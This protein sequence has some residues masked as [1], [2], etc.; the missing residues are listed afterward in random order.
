MRRITVIVI[1]AALLL[2]SGGCADIDWKAKAKEA[3][4]TLIEHAMIIAIAEYGDSKMEAVQWT[5]NYVESI[6][7]TQDVLKWVPYKGLI[8][9]AYDELWRVWYSSLRDAGYDTDGFI[10]GDSQIFV[11]MDTSTTVPDL[12]DALIALME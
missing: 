5:I 12:H 1:I 7:W 10:K 2:C 9:F 11:L 8:E 4:A 6:E 3:F